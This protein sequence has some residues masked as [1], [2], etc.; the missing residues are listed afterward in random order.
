MAFRAEARRVSQRYEQILARRAIDTEFVAGNWGERYAEFDQGDWATFEALHSH[1]EPSLH[2]RVVGQ[3]GGLIVNRW[4]ITG[5]RLVP[6]LRPDNAVKLDARKKPTKYI[7]PSKANPGQAKR[8]DVH[9]LVRDRLLENREEPIFL[10]LEG[11]LKADAVASTG[12]LAVSVP[13]VTLW[14]LEEE[15]LEPWLP[16]LRRASTVYV[17]TDSDY[18]GKRRGHSPGAAPQFVNGGEVRYFTDKCAIH[19]RSRYGLRIKYLVPP[20]LSAEEALRRGLGSDDRWKVGIDDHI[21]WGKNWGKWDATTNP[22]GLQ[23]FEYHRADWRQLPAKDGAYH[24]TDAR[25]RTFL[26]HLETTR[27]T[28]GLFSVSDLSDE[29]GWHRNTI[30]KARISCEARGA[31]E[32]WPGR[33]LGVGKGNKPHCFRFTQQHET[34]GLSTYPTGRV[35]AR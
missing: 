12:R 3:T 27:G 16:V 17:V 29:L 5:R 11:C 28:Y 7:Q 31:L 22:D 30:R 26:A 18:N 33:P 2:K 4:D 20:Y 1:P 14:K 10:C 6:Y 23:I 21:A 15:H 32:T 25:D 34:S 13:S 9:P 24:T 8:L 35:A 19:Y